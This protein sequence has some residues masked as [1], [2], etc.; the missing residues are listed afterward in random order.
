MNRRAYIRTTGTA[1][2][3]LALAPSLYRG[4]SMGKD[5]LHQFGLITNVVQ[6]S[7]R[8]DHRG[9][10]TRLAEMGYRY[11]EFGGTWGEDP[12]RLLTFMKEIGITPLAG[13]TS[14]AALQGDGLQKT[15]EDTLAME[16]KYMVCYWPWM[17]SAEN[18]TLN[19]VNAAVDRLQKIG[20]VCNR[21]GLRFAMHNHEKEFQQ[22]DGEVI[23]NIMLEHTDPELVTMEVDLYWAYKGGVDIREFFKA[24]PGRFELVH[25]K[26]ST[27]SP[28][29]RS[30]ACV[31]SGIIDF[32]DLL[33][34]RD[35]AGFRH[36]IV[37]HDQPEPE[38]ELECASSSLA[39][40][41]G[42]KF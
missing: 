36:L 5:P 26:D 8:N 19:Q 22:L 25:V 2:S 15:I 29:M 16:K 40:L 24:H 11:L 21:N 3:G 7:I 6:E 27:D 34:Y 17:D 35:M 32:P 1:L 18:L 13:G 42:L 37:E 14:M 23:Y 28:D 10:L 20:E 39:Y 31:G 38:A 33:S 41:Q 12:G 9:T 4:C 30:F